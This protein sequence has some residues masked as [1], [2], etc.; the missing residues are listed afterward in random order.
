MNDHN[1]QTAKELYDDLL[2]ERQNFTDRAERAAEITVPHVFPKQG[3]E[4]QTLPMPWQGDGARLSTNLASAITLALFPPN[5][6]GIRLDVG[7]DVKALA[8][9]NGVDESQLT[10]IFFQ[11][12]EAVRK[13]TEFGENRAKLNAAGLQL[14]I[15]GNCL[16]DLSNDSGMRV[17]TLRN[18]VV[19]RDG[20]ED[21]V[22]IV[23]QQKVH[24]TEFTKAQ[25]QA[26]LSIEGE[27]F[28][29]RGF[30]DVYTWCKKG[31]NNNWSVQQE[32]CGKIIDKPKKYKDDVL[33]FIPLR[34]ISSGTGEAYGR[35]YVELH[36]GDLNTLEVISQSLVT[37]SINAAKI[38]WLL[39]VGGITKARDLQNAKNGDVISGRVEDVRCLQ[40][41]KHADMSITKQQQ[42]ELKQNLS[43]AFL[44]TISS[45]RNSER[46]TATEINAVANAINRAMSGIYSTLAYTM[47]LRIFNIYYAQL[48]K[49]GDIPQLPFEV[50]PTVLTGVEALGRAENVEKIQTLIATIANL[51]ADKLQRVK[52]DNLIRE[53]SVALGMDIQGLFISDEELEQQR[54]QE[55][56]EQLMMQ[57]A[58]QQMGSMGQLP[59]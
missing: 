33:P 37:A 43:K 53:L 14:I 1:K 5:R 30:I 44:D 41:D 15:T 54:Q 11:H 2:P 34:L 50:T 40:M 13:R 26:I 49:K 42:A 35:G 59:A 24:K 25:Y 12:E 51:G 28:D 32:V 31:F 38:V 4:N 23:I 52:V 3:M 9:D 8:A 58:Q 48:K 56:Q 55:Q 39:N 47:Q 27:G 21:P 57:A 36:A 45:I 46:T 18:Y 19:Q 7:D 22:N 6:S 20:N 16:L 17:H 10:S 29:D